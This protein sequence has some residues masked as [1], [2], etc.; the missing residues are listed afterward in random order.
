MPDT[1]MNTAYSW[2]CQ[3]ADISQLQLAA[4]DIT[5]A[6]NLVIKINKV[7]GDYIDKDKNSNGTGLFESFST[8]MKE[9]ILNRI[10]DLCRQYDFNVKSEQLRKSFGLRIWSGCI[11]AAKTISLETMD[12]P[13]TPDLR[14]S[15]FQ[16]LD[17]IANNDPIFRLGVECTPLFKKYHQQCYSFNGVPLSSAVRKYPNEYLIDKV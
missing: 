5:K 1:N 2:A 11:S 9:V 14:T 15:I 17:S 8:Y 6:T 7:L 10:D 16:K 13:N 4:D 3:L 12:G